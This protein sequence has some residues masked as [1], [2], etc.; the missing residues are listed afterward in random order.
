MT[1]NCLLCGATAQLRH[2][3]YP[4]Y[5]QPATFALYHCAECNSAFSLPRVEPKTLYD[6]IYTNGDKVPGYARYWKYARTVKSLSNPLEYL[7]RKENTYWAIQ[8]ALSDFAP[9]TKSIKLLEVGSGLGYLTYSL[10]KAD[11]DVVGLDISVSA[12][13]EAVKTF[14]E[15]YVCSDVA[16]YANTRAKTFDVILLTDVIE[17]VDKPLVFLS[18]LKTLLRKNGRVIITTPNKS[19]YHADIL[20]ASELPPVHCWWLSEESMKYIANTLGMTLQFVKFTDFYKKTFC[21]ISQKTLLKR[22]KPH[23]YFDING[24]LILKEPSRRKRLKTAIRSILC[25]ITPA[26]KVYGKARTLL[27]KNFA[28]C[29][30]RGVLLCAIMQGP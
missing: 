29:G 5:Q 10:R 15:Y 22:Q 1:T 4:G 7:S 16:E 17:H 26:I 20:W 28:V 23:P 8:K 2:E 30:D 25:K 24:E 11:Y 3:A 27:D 14:G 9:K 6:H 21:A 19:F 13:K 18:T 12:I